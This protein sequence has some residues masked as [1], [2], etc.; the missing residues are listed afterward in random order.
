MSDDFRINTP[1]NAHGPNAPLRR[2]PSPLR[3]FLRVAGPAVAAI[4]LVFL[5]IGLGDFF[6][7]LG[8]FRPPRYF[9]CAFVGMPLLAGGVALTRFAYLGPLARYVAEETAPVGKDVINY[10]ARG[11][12]P[13]VRSVASALKDEW[14]KSPDENSKSCPQCGQRNDADARFCAH[15]G[16]A[17]TATAVCAHCGAKNAPS[18]TFCDQ[19]GHALASA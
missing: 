8:S 6:M 18:A 12:E 2:G 9:W 19:C 13:A 10:M 15:C 14:S 16:G 3:D 1:G 5:L 11:T 4:G 17:M 7:A